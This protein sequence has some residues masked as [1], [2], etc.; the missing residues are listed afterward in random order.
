MSATSSLNAYA[1]DSYTVDNTVVSVSK[2]DSVVTKDKGSWVWGESILDI[3]T[4]NLTGIRESPV[5]YDLFVDKPDGTYIKQ[6]D[7]D[8]NYHGYVLSDGSAYFCGKTTNGLNNKCDKIVAP[9]GLSPAFYS[10]T[11]VKVAMGPVT[12]VALRDDGGFNAVVANYYN[13]MKS[14]YYAA[15]KLPEKFVDVSAG[16]RTALALGESG[17][18]YSISFNEMDSTVATVTKIQTPSGV[19]FK[20]VYVDQSVGYDDTNKAIDGY[21]AL[22]I[23][24]NLYRWGSYRDSADKLITTAT[25]AKIALPSGVKI[26]KFKA[27]GG[28]ESLLDQNGDIWIW[29]QGSPEVFGNGQKGGN[30]VYQATPQKVARPEGIRFVNYDLTGSRATALDQNGDAWTWGTNGIVGNGTIMAQ[31][32]NNVPAKWLAI[33]SST[34]N[35]TQTIINC[36]PTTGEAP[37]GLA[38]IGAVALSIG[39]LGVVLARRRYSRV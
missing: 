32:T 27:F 22:D 16:N 14:S 31:F 6:M 28:T 38:S 25:P 7:S 36:M 2:G 17:S 10:G 20:N 5:S 8:G 4:G 35:T 34:S 9:N 11:A 21:Y 1:A 23:N 3:S 26:V 24:G 37:E 19:K 29:G 18:I 12:Y 39:L 30:A 15:D 33:S 13:E